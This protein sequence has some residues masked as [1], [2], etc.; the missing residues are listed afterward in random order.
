MVMY[1]EL[2][3]TGLITAD[4]HWSHWWSA[5][6]H[7]CVLQ[8]MSIL[9]YVL[10][11]T[12]GKPVTRLWLRECWLVLQVNHFHN[13]HHIHVYGTDIPE[14]VATFEQLQSDYDVDARIMSNLRSLGFHTPTVIE[15]Q[16]ITVMLHVCHCVIFPSRYLYDLLVLII[17]QVWKD[18][19]FIL[20][21][22][23]FWLPPVR[24]Y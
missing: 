17:L 20:Q 24:L 19:M 13:Q 18:C 16:A 7:I 14:P 9:K 12:W 1:S 5:D 10:Y 3:A 22:I 4:M 21:M 8:E 15:M 2:G 6:G 11:I 23:L